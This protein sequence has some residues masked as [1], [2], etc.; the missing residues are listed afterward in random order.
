[1]RRERGVWDLD[2]MLFFAQHPDDKPR[3]YLRRSPRRWDW[4]PS[5][6]GRYPNDPPPMRAAQST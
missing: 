2:L 1:L 4:G 6:F 5:K 3:P